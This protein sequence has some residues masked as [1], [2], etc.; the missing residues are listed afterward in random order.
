[1]K[2]FAALF[3]VTVLGAALMAAPDEKKGD[4][5]SGASD[6]VNTA[7]DA[8]IADSHASVGSDR[9]GTR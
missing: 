7:T 4:A 8:P 1:M 5:K 6:A 2:K 3:G 9:S